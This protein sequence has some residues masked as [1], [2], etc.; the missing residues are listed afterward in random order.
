MFK[1]VSGFSKGKAI[2]MIV[3]LE[4]NDLRN[5]LIRTMN[6]RN[7]WLLDWGSVSYGG[8]YIIFF[9]FIAD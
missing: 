3:W 2:A 4:K 1:Q 8:E 7:K 9:F 6:I 5:N